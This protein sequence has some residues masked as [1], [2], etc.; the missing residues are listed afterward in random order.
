[1]S[2]F[3]AEVVGTMILM[4]L[5]GGIVVNH[6]LN[7]S[8]GQ[9]LG[10]SK[11]RV[12]MKKYFLLFLLVTLSLTVIMSGC[13][14]TAVPTVPSG[15]LTDQSEEI[16]DIGKLDSGN[17]IFL[18]SG[19]TLNGT[20]INPSNPTLTVNSGESITGTLKVQAI[21]SGT[22]GNV[23][24]FGYTPSWG[25]HSSSYVTVRS[26][27]PVGTSSYD[28]SINLN[29]PTTPGT[30]YLIFAS[31]CEM[32]LGWTMSQTNWTT[33]TMSWNDG[34]DIADLTE[35]EL[36]DSISTGYL[37]LDMLV[38]STYSK[39]NYCFSYFAQPRPDHHRHL[40]RSPGKPERLYRPL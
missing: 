32:N 10:Y 20:S 14:K 17:K 12:I 30:Y 39:S 34:N 19:G 24:P 23:V 16:E 27:L 5:G 26:D 8:K 31:N 40:L 7:K 3:W 11:G 22:S 37:Y 21:Y 4:L 13:L 33:G 29:A 25:S 15:S 9:S 38:G 2:V 1:M 28:V 18:E 36:Q 35:S 6:V